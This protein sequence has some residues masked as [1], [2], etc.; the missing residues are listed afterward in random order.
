LSNF[1]LFVI[2]IVSIFLA[3]FFSGSET[4]VVSC[5]KV[6][7]RHRS[8]AG[9]GSARTIEWF[10]SKPEQF[11]STVLVGTNISV[12]ICTA[13]A[14]ALCVYFFQSKGALIS[15]VVMTPVILIL[16]EVI[17]KSVFL[18]YADRIALLSAP[19]LKLFYYIL[20][21]IVFPSTLLVRMVMR[22]AGPEGRRGSLLSSREELIY[23]YAT[24]KRDGMLQPQESLIMDRVLRFERVS[25]KDIMVP[26]DRV[27]AFPVTASVDEVIEEAN[28]YSYY[29]FPVMTPDG[30]K[31][32]GIISF[33][34]LLGLDGG[35][36]LSRVMHTPLFTSV[37]ESAERLLIK[38]KRESMHMAIVLDRHSNFA[39]IVTLE[40]ILESIVG[41][42]YSEHEALDL[43]H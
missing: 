30:K 27:I 22:A 2:I 21:P 4:A 8:K 37:D 10:L 35:E 14:T 18:Y 16:G 3:A 17:P 19:A 28:K 23:L 38:M 13:S 12:I 6:K 7:V 34:D 39:G 5:S 32:I 15:T 41:N 33:F 36:R 20:F 43:E 9:S 29:R 1:Y 31:V 40:N 11:F 24:G 25:I 26:A 42:I